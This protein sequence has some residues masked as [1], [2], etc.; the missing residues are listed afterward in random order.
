MI[1]SLFLALAPS[2]RGETPAPSP[3]GSTVEAP[4]KGVFLEENS[5][6]ILSS[7][8][9][10]LADTA[11]ARAE[12]YASRLQNI[13]VLQ[14]EERFGVSRDIFDSHVERLELFKTILSSINVSFADR[15]R[16]EKEVAKL[17]QGLRGPSDFSKS[18]PAPP[19]TLSFADANKDRLEEMAKK[20]ESWRTQIALGE[21]ALDT[22]LDA[23]RAAEKE[24]RLVRDGE[25]GG[26]A[27]LW[28]QNDAVLKRDTLRALRVLER[29]RLENLKIEYRIFEDREKE[30]AKVQQQIVRHLS[31]DEKDRDTQIGKYQALM[32]DLQ[33]EAEGLLR[34]RQQNERAL[35]SARGQMARVSGDQEARPVLLRIA[36]REAE[37]EL[38]R[39]RLEHSALMKQ[40]VG[41]MQGIWRSRYALLRGEI[42]AEALQGTLDSATA[43]SREIGKQIDIQQGETLRIQ[44]NLSSL[45]KEMDNPEIT[46]ELRSILEQTYKA[47]AELA[48]R[49]RE[50]I[51]FLL[52]NLGVTDNA[53]AELRAAMGK[54]SLAKK[55]NVAWQEQFWSIWKTELWVADERPITVGKITSAVLLMLFGIVVSVYISRKVAQRLER[56]FKILPTSAMAVQRLTFYVLMVANVLWALA[57]VGIPLTA[58]AFLGGAL[59]IGM[60]LG[61]QT[62]FSQVISGFILTI[63]KPI[64][65]GDRIQIGDAHGKVVL[66]GSRYTRIRTFDNLDVLVPN[67][68]F[69]S[70]P[71]TNW[72]LSSSLVRGKLSVGVSYASPPEI[73]QDILLRAV[74]AHESVLKKPAP[75]VRFAD[76]AENSLMFELF[77]WVDLNVADPTE[78]TH[79][80]R[81]VLMR[82]FAQKGVELAF[83]QRDVHLDF[84]HPLEVRRA[85]KDLDQGGGAGR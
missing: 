71:V 31:F 63:Q 47:V 79:D 36:Q 15:V 5:F 35:T 69:L 64:R 1:L 18:L 73:V 7:A 58:F 30:L 51:S 27:N 39:Q 10:V 80:L 50:F 33:K 65:I 56:H 2:A 53:V 72:P 66:I 83:P 34:Q 23:R 41:P 78:V 45:Q 75:F 3:G 43:I 74:E 21:Q 59:A 8:D 49:K 62:L 38:T 32:E 81:F 68:H 9:L 55:I 24:V 4:M 61:A 19:Y 13:D 46:K 77:F 17:D 22:L 82:E 85:P 14:V 48:E 54:V 12:Q 67:E 76:F 37:L 25:H 52:E 16:L 20:K 29:L 26:A 44:K 40:V 11:L 60:G 57:T 28:L 6:D 70:H 42:P 84:V